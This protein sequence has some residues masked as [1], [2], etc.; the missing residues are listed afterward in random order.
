MVCSTIPVELDVCLLC[1]GF[2]QNPV[3]PIPPNFL[4]ASSPSPGDFSKP[5]FDQTQ[6]PKVMPIVNL[7]WKPLDKLY[8]LWT[9]CLIDYR[10]KRNESVSYGAIKADFGIETVEHYNIY[11]R[12]AVHK[13]LL[14]GETMQLTP[15][16]VNACLHWKSIAESIYTP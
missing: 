16:G 1:S 3:T 7:K 13:N 5:V 2:V 14:D 9:I 10:R 11:C 12:I 6:D 4:L 15:L 8:L